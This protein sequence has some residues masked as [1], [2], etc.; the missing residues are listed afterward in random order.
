ME[1]PL[2]LAYCGG[3]YHFMRWVDSRRPLLHALSVAGFFVLGFMTKFVAALFLPLVCGLTLPIAAAARHRFAIRWRDWLAAAILAS[4]VITPWFVHQ[5]RLNGQY[6]WDVILGVHVYERFTSSLDA[7]HLEPWHFYLSRTW[8]ELGHAGG[9]VAAAVALLALSVRALL[10]GPWQLRLLLVWWIVPFTLISLGT[11]KLFHYGYPFLPPIALGI[12]WAAASVVAAVD[13]P[14]GR[15]VAAGLL[16]ARVSSAWLRTTLLVAGVTMVA[17]A[18]ASAVSGGVVWRVGGVRLLQNT[19]IIRPL[20]IGAFLFAAAGLASM[21]LRLIALV[22]LLLALPVSDY[23]VRA[24]RVRTV[25]QRLRVIRDCA[26]RVGESGSAAATG[27]YNAARTRTNHSHYYYL[28]EL[29]PWIEPDMPSE[30]AVRAR[31]LDAGQA[32]PVLMTLEDYD[33]LRRLAAA[34]VLAALPPAVVVDGV[35]VVLPGPFSVCAAAARAAGAQAPA[36]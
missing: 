30:E 19:S 12:G 22:V 6:F 18:I 20:V 35:A 32:T 34:G 13:T 25:D 29:G 1:A 24:S 23:T 28:F 16:R 27:L 10:G 11:S 33:K 26:A 2:F 17:L 3:V 8:T 36:P 4:A 21:S 14:R 15:T 31:L 5:W 9:R 7:S